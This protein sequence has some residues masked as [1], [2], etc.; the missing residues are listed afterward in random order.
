MALFLASVDGCA[1][2]S[3][4]FSAAEIDQ[5]CEE[6]CTQ[7]PFSRCGGHDFDCYEDCNQGCS[8]ETGCRAAGVCTQQLAKRNAC[9]LDHMCDGIRC[10]SENVLYLGCHAKIEFGDDLCPSVATC[11]VSMDACLRA[12]DGLCY[13]DWNRYLVCLG[14]WTDPE[15]SNNQCE[16]I[17]CSNPCGACEQML[18]QFYGCQLGL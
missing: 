8:V 14:V 3:E 9:R 13:W 2:E 10:E 16:I 7:D 4:Q 17:D 15:S 5:L 12:Y 6:W 1:D 18:N 11:G